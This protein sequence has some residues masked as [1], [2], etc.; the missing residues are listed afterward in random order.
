MVVAI[1][2]IV[3]LCAISSV[4]LGCSS[5]AP[6]AQGPINTQANATSAAPSST[7][8]APAESTNSAAPPA[9]ELPPV[10]TAVGQLGPDFAIS[11]TDGRP[12][13]TADLRALDKPYILYYFATW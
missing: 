1:R 12:L 6:T 3:I 10:G 7:A 4:L 9:G 13:T 8:R 11:Y 2:F 5:A